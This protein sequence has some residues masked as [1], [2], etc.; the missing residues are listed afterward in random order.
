MR[1]AFITL[2]FGSILGSLPLAAPADA[3]NYPTKPIRLICPFPPGGVADVTAR[4]VG[5]KMSEVLG[6][7]VLVE[8]RPG[9]SGLIG[10]DLAAKA[11]PDGYTLLMTTGD[12][13][14]TPT[15]M[16]PMSFDPHKALIP[17]IMATTAPLVLAAGAESGINNIKELIAAAKAKPGGLAFSSPGNGTINHVAVEWLAL[18]AGLKLLHVP[19]KGGAPAAVA[20]A[21]GEVQLGAVTPSSGMQYVRSGKA[22]VIALMTKVRPS[23]TPSSWPTLDEAGVPVD[24]ALWVGLFAP[25]GTP[26]AIV[27]KLNADVA[28]ILQDESVRK[29]LNDVGTEASPMSQQQFRERI[30]T[31]AARYAKVVQQAGIKVEH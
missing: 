28:R 2:V 31:D 1:S 18:E 29:R 27:S 4:V 10:V 24:A 9:A 5:Q 20:V 26:A 16:P 19:Y 11:T 23:F 17:I 8:N 3:Q 30:Q 22:K 21:A 15:S 7:Q 14:T 13:L 6:Q 12:F 25:A